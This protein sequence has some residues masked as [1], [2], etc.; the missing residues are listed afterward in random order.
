MPSGHACNACFLQQQKRGHEA[1]YC[2]QIGLQREALSFWQSFL[3]CCFICFVD[4]LCRL[5]KYTNC[6]KYVS[7][8]NNTLYNIWNYYIFMLLYKQ[9]TMKRVRGA[10]IYHPAQIRPMETIPDAT[11]C[12]DSDQPKE[13]KPIPDWVRLRSFQYNGRML[14]AA[15]PGICIILSLAGELLLSVIVVGALALHL[16]DQG[17]SKRISLIIYMCF[18]IV[19]QSC[20]IYSA[21]P[22][23]WITLYNIA[24]LFILNMFM[25]LTGGW[26]VLQFDILLREE[27][28]LAE[29]IEVSLFTIYPAASVIITSWTIATVVS[30]KYLHYVVIVHGFL[31]LRLFITPNEPS[32]RK[33]NYRASQAGI[34]YVIG[35]AEIALMM[36]FYSIAPA[37]I[38]VVFNF[39]NLANYAVAVELLLVISTP[40]F[41]VSFLELRSWAE[42]AAVPFKAVSVVRWVS[43]FVTLIATCVLLLQAKSSALVPWLLPV[44]LGNVLLGSLSNYKKSTMKAV[45][46]IVAAIIGGMYVVAVLGAIPWHMDIPG[47]DLSSITFLL[48]TCAVLSIICFLVANAGSKSLLSTLVILDM[49]I[50]VFLEYTLTRHK[51][52]SPPLLLATT[53]C[54][55][56]LLTRLHNA[57]VVTWHAAWIGTAVH[58]INLLPLLQSLNPDSIE[59]TWIRSATVLFLVLVIS[60]L[61]FFENRLA[62]PMMSVYQYVLAI[63]VSVMLFYLAV[64]RRLWLV[65]FGV[66]PTVQD[67]TSSFIII[68][69][70]ICLKLTYFHMTHHLQA[71][72][73]NIMACVFGLMLL[74]LQPTIP[75]S[76]LELSDW[77]I[78]V[79]SCLILATASGLL[80]PTQHWIPLFVQSVMVGVA[81][82]TYVVEN[83][84]T[85]PTVQFP[86]A[87]LYIC[88]CTVCAYICFSVWNWNFVKAPRRSSKILNIKVSFIL[89]VVVSVI[90]LAI[91]GSMLPVARITLSSFAIPGTQLHCGIYLLVAL[92]LRG[93]CTWQKSL[94]PLNYKAGNMPTLT[95]ICA[96]ICYLFA[97]LNCPIEPWEIWNCSCAIVFLLV[98]PD[99]VLMTSL[100]AQKQAGLLLTVCTLN[101]YVA[102][103]VHCDLWHQGLGFFCLVEFI[104]LISVLPVYVALGREFCT[105]FTSSLEL[106]VFITPLN[107]ILYI[108]GSSYTSW[109]LATVGL[110][111]GTWVMIGKLSATY[112]TDGQRNSHK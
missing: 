59:P 67:A 8:Y 29:L 6:F 91:E 7:V 104:I 68:C 52:C 11:G 49:T 106:I 87:L 95:N 77:L 24:F 84:L 36:M 85:T 71:R 32:F 19:A 42:H 105:S 44:T 62:L 18:F 41:L 76:V 37:I 90:T 38:F 21:V 50:F 73:A 78:I 22:L 53:T 61:I 98:Q 100:P 33:S 74:V 17:G 14:A 3:K 102:S 72:K 92:I 69:G 58:A 79:S 82:G 86:T 56:Y 81:S 10:D 27:P 5:L 96:I 12:A 15:L 34:A 65:F 43:G 25:V 46:Y 47:L 94:D 31:L 20:V 2:P 64:L 45:T 4:Y 30:S 26:I 9:I 40:I 101:L 63:C 57:G 93:H 60:K 107:T 103:A 89:L 110:C 111:E 39:W 23:L 75:K 83:L 66:S 35:A 112:G 109:L 48:I 55:V 97:I 70:A 99:P 88:P 108:V 1:L 28:M 16:A 13:P 54:A 80:R 51:L